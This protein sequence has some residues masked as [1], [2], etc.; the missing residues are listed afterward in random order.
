MKGMKIM[1]DGKVGSPASQIVVF[2][3]FMSFMVNSLFMPFVVP[4][5]AEAD[6]A[7]AGVAS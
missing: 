7:F 4:V 1:K 6:R 2:M 5:S 3:I